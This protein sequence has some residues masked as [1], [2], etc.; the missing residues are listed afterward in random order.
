MS[1]R[2]REVKRFDQFADE[3]SNRRVEEVTVEG[4]AFHNPFDT[5]NTSSLGRVG[6]FEHGLVYTT[7]TP[8]G[9]L[10]YRE[11]LFKAFQTEAQASP[12]AMA[13]LFLAAEVRVDTLQELLPDAVVQIGNGHGEALA[14]ERANTL[15][16]EAAMQ[17]LGVA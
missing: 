7:K 17:V 5:A 14:S 12:A 11:R 9:E 15:H 13:K 2:T 1:K 6:F 10:R 4:A 3:L 8:D 16:A